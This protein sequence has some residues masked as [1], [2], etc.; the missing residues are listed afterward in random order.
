MFN[1]GP[2]TGESLRKY[3]L[4]LIWVSNKYSDL[5]MATHFVSDISPGSYSDNQNSAI[6]SEYPL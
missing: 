5:P 1:S 2:S 3:H 4:T 6:I